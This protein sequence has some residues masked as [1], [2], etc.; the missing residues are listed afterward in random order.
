MKPQPLTAKNTFVTR[1]E[2]ENAAG[3]ELREL[4]CSQRARD[5]RT[6]HDHVVSVFLRAHGNLS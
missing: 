4:P 3:T 5:P 6:H 2:N 1:L